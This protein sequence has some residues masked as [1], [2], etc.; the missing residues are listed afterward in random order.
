MIVLRPIRPADA[1]AL[2]PLI[3][4]TGVAD[5]LIWDGPSSLEEYR[6]MIGWRSAQAA[7]GDAHAFVILLEN[8]TAIGSISLRPMAGRFR[9][10]IGVWIG[11]PFQRRGYGTEAVRKT[12]DYGL[13]LGLEKIDAI[14]LVG[15]FA[16]RRIFKNNGFRLEGTLRKAV[17]KHDKLVDEW[18]LGLTRE[19]AAPMSSRTPATVLDSGPFAQ[20]VRNWDAIAQEISSLARWSA[21]QLEDPGITAQGERLTT[22]RLEGAWRALALGFWDAQW[23]ERD[24]MEELLI[25]LVDSAAADLA[26]A[27]L[28]DEESV[29]S[30]LREQPA[31]FTEPG[32]SSVQKELGKPKPDLV[33]FDLA[34]IAL[35]Q[36][37]P[38][39]ASLG[40]REDRP[41]RMAI[42][43]R[44][45]R[46]QRHARE[47]AAAWP[48]FFPATPPP[49]VEC[50][51]V[52]VAD[53]VSRGAHDAKR[54]EAMARALERMG[55]PSQ[56]GEELRQKHLVRER[57]RSA[58]ET[59]SRIG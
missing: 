47:I 24:R 42:A 18:V 34:Q 48:Q 12:V 52:A 28:V 9:A 38:D 21:E 8:G 1:D 49:D 20:A 41:V 39:F 45:F 31:K 50:I 35:A 14:I 33:Q 57:K 29:T 4:G 56:S 36:F 30:M 3:F 58:G 46:A 44:Q 23:S 37:D 55:L 32:L 17:R 10:D 26:I 22:A 2:F 6:E 54:W 27:A 16:S 59:T 13:S 43:L 53:S 19:D 7:R 11:V 25:S 5:S 40:E 51:R 15:N